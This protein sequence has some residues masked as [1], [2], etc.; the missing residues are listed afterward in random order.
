MRPR[1]KRDRGER[2]AVAGLEGVMLGV[3]VLV[4]GTLLVINAWSVL[5]ARRTLDGAA[6]EY[7]RAYTQA[8]EPS[9]ADAAGRRALL[10]V[11]GGERGTVDGV[12]V[13]APDPSTFGPCATATVTLS[14]VVPAARL[15]FVGPVASTTVA[16]THTELVDAH[17][18]VRSGPSY[19]VERTACAE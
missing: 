5:Q 4:T 15:P 3:L 18:E 1:W 19:D 11:L 14:I 13:E 9:G 10:D 17:R 16:V 8:D 6:R 12:T 2:G 7:L